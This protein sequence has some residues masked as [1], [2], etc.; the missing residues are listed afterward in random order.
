METK[1]LFEEY[2]AGCSATIESALLSLKDAECY[3]IRY[4]LGFNRD[5]LERLLVINRV[6]LTGS[7]N[8]ELL[9]KVFAKI[10]S[11]AESRRF[12]LIG[13]L[14]PEYDQQSVIFYR[15]QGFDVMCSDTGLVLM[16]MD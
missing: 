11:Y 12:I 7:K 14:N 6:R 5:L 9:D 8:L 2:H 13:E 4:E 1:V 15:S 16:I 10:I 3:N